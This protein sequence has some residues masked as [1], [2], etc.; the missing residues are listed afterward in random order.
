MKIISFLGRKCSGKDTA[1]KIVCYDISYRHIS[2]YGDVVIKTMSFAKP[3]KDTLIALTGAPEEYF[4]D[5]KMKEKPC[6]EYNNKMFTPR[7]LMT[8]FGNLMREKFGTDFWLNK[9]KQELENHDKNVDFVL[10]TDVRFTEEVKMIND[11]GGKIIYID[12]DKILGPMS[13]D[14]DISEKVVYESKEWAKENAADYLEISNHVN[15]I[16]YLTMQLRHKLGDI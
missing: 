4:Y 6:I 12:R 8:W 3:L 10:V 14:A 16:G 5:Q 1:A 11:M 9:F 15:S 7:E 13:D 2:K